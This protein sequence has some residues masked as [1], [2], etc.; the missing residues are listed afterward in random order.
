MGLTDPELDPGQ[1]PPV[2]PPTGAGA[3]EQDIAAATAQVIASDI[4]FFIRL[5]L[6]PQGIGVKRPT[7]APGPLHSSILSNSSLHTPHSGQVQSSGRSSKLV[8]GAM[9]CVGSPT[10]GS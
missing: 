7:S 9:F 6:P 1:P 2:P 10:A 8:P 5:R 3:R 4:S